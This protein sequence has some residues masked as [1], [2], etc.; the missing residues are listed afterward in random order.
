[1]G[2]IFAVTENNGH[3]AERE[4][5]LQKIR[6]RLDSAEFVQEMT[7]IFFAAKRVALT[8]SK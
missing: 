1:M 7:G 5:A 3:A 6:E 2:E 4:R 8:K